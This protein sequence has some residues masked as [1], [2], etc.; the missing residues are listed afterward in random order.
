MSVPEWADTYRKLAAEAGSTGGPFQ[1]SRVEAA[2]G[3]MLAMTEPGVR[4][5]TLM[6]CTQLLKTTVLENAFGFHAHLDP[7]PILLLQP[8]EDAAKQFSKER[9]APMVRKTPE[10][11]R[12]MSTK[13]ARDD[14]VLFKPFPGGFLALAGAGSPDNLARRPIRLLLAD[15]I[16]KYPVTKE[17]DPIALAEERQATFDSNSLSIRA[18]SPT[19]ADESRIEA[20]YQSSD[21]R[22]AS[23][24]CPNCR[25]RMFPAFS[26]IEWEKR[27]R[28]DGSV[29]EHLTDTAGIVCEGCGLKWSEGDRLMALRSIRWHQTRPFDCCDARRAPLEDYAAAWRTGSDN[30]IGAAWQWWED[31]KTHRWAVYRAVCPECG[32]FGLSNAHAGFHAS[33]LLSPW[34]KDRPRDIARKW[35]GAQDNVDLLQA[36]WNTQMGLAYRATTGRS[37]KVDELLARREVW[38]ARV[39]AGAAVLTASMDTQ[40]TWVELETVGWGLDEESW[41]IDHTRI[42]GEFS[43]PRVQQLV[44]D[45]LLRT[46]RDAHGRPYRVGAACFDSGGTHTQDVYNFC[47]ARI[48]R[49]VWAIK[50]ASER[51]GQRNPVWPT[52]KPSRKT[53]ATYRPIILGGNTARDTIRARLTMEVPKPGHRHPGYMHFPHDRDVIYFEQLLADRRELRDVGGRRFTV[54]VTPAGR[55]NEAS[56][57]KVY[58][59]AA[60]CGLQHMGLRLNSRVREVLEAQPPTDEAP[61]VPDAPRP[62]PGGAPPERRLSITEQGGPR[63]SITSRIA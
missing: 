7:A 9:I 27:R 36:W 45:Y 53:K 34:Q 15:E 59:Y 50:G 54:W 62:P 35:I 33:K 6:S 46:W 63:K 60:L 2:R 3:P 47:K 11:R 38:D 41:S 39:P 29:A 19:V 8:K 32:S 30:P 5:I 12:V 1:T 58:N 48:G 17:G 49:R 25:H 40:D 23:L 28:A 21:Q 56:D 13:R 37:L 57:L 44:D 20:S 16:D 52:K 22:R 31:D 43:D 26:S 42:E 18:C 4:T 14:E 24:E 51:D 61:G 10:L 55:A